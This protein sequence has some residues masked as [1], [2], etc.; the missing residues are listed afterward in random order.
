MRAFTRFYLSFPETFQGISNAIRGL[1][2]RCFLKTHMLVIMKKGEFMFGFGK[3]KFES[4]TLDVPYNEKDGAKALGA[5]WDAGSK[6]WYAPTQKIKDKCKKWWPSESSSN[7]EAEYL[8]ISGPF[9]L[10]STSTDCYR[11]GKTSQI[12]A[13]SVGR[14]KDMGEDEWYEEPFILMH[15]KFIPMALVPEIQKANKGFA[16]KFSKQLGAKAWMNHCD[17]CNAHFGDFFLTAEPGGPFYPSS[18]Y[19]TDHITRRSLDINLPNEKYLGGFITDY[20]TGFG[21][22][23]SSS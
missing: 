1:K 17:H 16:L 18:E 2:P 5:R 12:G 7:E 8:S 19:D 20:K 3:P 21:M 15:M 13:I 6:K 23:M 4:F 22:R 14:L 9:E 10:L 11:C